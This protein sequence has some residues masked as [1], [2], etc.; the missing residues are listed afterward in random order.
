M[1]IN[2]IVINYLIGLCFLIVSPTYA[3][4]WTMQNIAG[5]GGLEFAPGLDPLSTGFNAPGAMAVDT[6]GNIYFTVPDQFRIYRIKDGVLEIFHDELDDS[7]IENRLNGLAID[8]QNNVYYTFSQT[9]PSTGFYDRRYYIW[10]RDQYGAQTHIAGTGY[11]GFP[12]MDGLSA[13]SNPIG[14]ATCLKILS[15]KDDGGWTNDFLYYTGSASNQNFIQKIVLTD[16]S[17]P[18]HRVAGTD[19]PDASEIVEGAQ[20]T[21]FPISVDSGLAWDSAGNLYY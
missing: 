9:S 4:D 1:K 6:N 5:N 16:V 19:H 3:Q 11:E 15:V 14:A 13:S 8:S 17:L 2:R 12:P 21:D 10:K 20:A 7:G 18:S